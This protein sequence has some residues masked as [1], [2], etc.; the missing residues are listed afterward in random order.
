MALAEAMYHISVPRLQRPMPLVSSAD[1]VY[2]Q[3]L[4]TIAGVPPL[5]DQKA[6]NLGYAQERIAAISRLVPEHPVVRDTK[7][8]PDVHEALYR[9]WNSP[10]SERRQMHGEVLWAM[11]GVKYYTRVDRM[12]FW[13][14]L[15]KDSYAALQ[16]LA[17]NAVE[18][19]RLARRAE[20][21]VAQDSNFLSRFWHR[22]VFGANVSDLAPL[23]YGF[24]NYKRAG[25]HYASLQRRQKRLAAQLQF[26]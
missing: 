19:V 20:K 3:G 24:D 11:A 22:R 7:L 21:E 15:A 18:F 26:A 6:F 13:Q 1:Y 23:L 25:K 4:P 8:Q 5:R 17:P 9:V 2:P 16:R 10:V 14:E 12:A